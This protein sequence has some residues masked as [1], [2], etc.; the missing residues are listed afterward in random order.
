M[1]H[2]LYLRPMAPIRI[3]P[4]LMLLI[5][6]WLASAVSFAPTFGRAATVPRHSDYCHCPHCSGGPTCCCRFAGKCPTP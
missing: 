1:N 3:G 6:F 4:M 2:A 5:A